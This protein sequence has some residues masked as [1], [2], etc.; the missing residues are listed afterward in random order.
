MKEN[1]KISDNT[2][3]NNPFAGFKTIEISNK[4]QSKSLLDVFRSFYFKYKSILNN[5]FCV[6]L[7]IQFADT[8]LDTTTLPPGYVYMG[9]FYQLFFAIITF[10]FTLTSLL[11]IIFTILFEEQVD[12][13]CKI[14]AVILIVAAIMYSV[15]SSAYDTSKVFDFLLCIAACLG[16]SYKKILKPLLITGTVI[17]LVALLLSQA[18]LISDY[19]Y[20]PGR[21]SLGIIYCTDFG[22]HVFFLVMAYMILRKFTPDNQTIIIALITFEVCFFIAMAKTASLCILVALAGISIEF[23]FQ[24]Y[25]KKSFFYHFK[26]IMLII[27]PLAYISFCLLTALYSYYPHIFPNNTFTARFALTAYAFDEFG[28]DLF[29]RYIK[30]N[31]NGGSAAADADASSNA[32]NLLDF[33]KAGF[34]RFSYALVI[35]ILIII[36]CILFAK[37]LYL[38]GVTTSLISLLMTAA[39]G[40]VVKLAHRE[41]KSSNTFSDYFWL[42][43]SF[44]RIIFCDGIVIFVIVLLLS[45][46]IQYRAFKSENY[47]FMFIMCVIALDCTIEHHL[48]D[49]SY[50]FIFMLALTDYFDTN[51]HIKHA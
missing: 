26:Y 31:G 30:Q 6:L 38:Y 1:K 37:K 51:K 25:K 17:M 45:L 20:S 11:T 8:F 46:F 3:I 5:V 33:E 32:S 14:T 44:M 48:T 21:R 23:L 7:C 27:Y 13:L 16:K 39:P 2:S 9:A 28:L 41:I 12:K 35:I 47:L 36:A 19:V 49:I 42:D 18:G 22:A 50:N 4:T 24:K 10:L 15:T 40:I 43:S 29:G 34:Y